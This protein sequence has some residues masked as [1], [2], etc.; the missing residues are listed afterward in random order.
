V[1]PYPTQAR[2]VLHAPR[3]VMAKRI[4]A[5]Y[6]LLEV[7]DAERCLLQCGAHALDH[8]A[9]WL[10]AFDVDFEVL[11]PV[12]LKERLARAGERLNRSVGAT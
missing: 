2:I 4:P 7:I 10:L 5:A 12:A 11:E 3:E 8:L 6:G 9:Y 1:S